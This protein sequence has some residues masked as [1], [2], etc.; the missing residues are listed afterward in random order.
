M[1][2]PK[3]EMLIL[4]FTVHDVYD[5]NDNKITLE[6]K[7]YIK[8]YWK[9]IKYKNY[10][11]F[12]SKEINWFCEFFLPYS[13]GDCIENLVVQIWASSYIKTK[14]KIAYNYININNVE[15]KSKIN[16]KTE[17]IG[18]RKGLKIIYSLQIMCY[19]LYKFMKS[20][21]ML[22]LDKIS[23][24]KMMQIHK[25]NEKSNYWLEKNNLFDKYLISLFEKK[26]YEKANTALRLKTI[27]TQKIKTKIKSNLKLKWKSKLKR[28]NKTKSKVSIK[29]SQLNLKNISSITKKNA[30]KTS[31]KKI[32]INV[33][34]KD[35]DSNSKHKKYFLNIGYK[36]HKLAPKKTIKFFNF[37]FTLPDNENDIL[38][39]TTNCTSKNLAY[40][41]FNKARCIYYL[42]KKIKKEKL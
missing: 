20:T 12:F 6:E 14:R 22:I 26:N 32:K 25:K 28:K 9:N 36:I 30:K 24:Y 34:P 17:L 5:T 27:K 19:S 16:G 33:K 29:K 40:P 10:L 38:K 7:P 39:T 41:N 13:L 4:H 8:F 31:K 2:L 18:R 11:K 15:K 37:K 35:V 23:I 21:Q 42:L 1:F 3:D